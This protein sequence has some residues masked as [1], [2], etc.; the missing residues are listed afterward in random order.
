MNPVTQYL[1]ELESTLHQLPE[2]E[3]LKVI[4]LLHQ[5]R[6]EQRQ[7][8]VMGNGGSASTATHMVC[9]LAKNTRRRGLPNFR[10]IGLADNMAIF[11]A[12][13]NDEG[14]ENVFAQQLASFVREGDIVIAIS[15][16]GKSPNVIKAAEL[17]RS[18]GAHVIGMTGFDGGK[19]AGLSNSHLHVPSHCIEHVE[20]AHL[21][22][23]HLIAKALRERAHNFLLTE[24]LQS[25]SPG[26]NID[27][28]A[29]LDC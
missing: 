25:L 7:I 21:M 26:L 5:A 23:E 10:V 4:D 28:P 20:D 3:I 29:R 19:L 15:A 14:Y 12:L 16:S 11:S 27:E 13:A 9:D 24:D 18:I 2:E 8:F 1:A 22:I 17:A 6:L